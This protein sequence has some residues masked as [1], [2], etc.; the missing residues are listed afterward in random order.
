MN[1]HKFKENRSHVPI[2]EM[3]INWTNFLDGVDDA[4]FESFIG[5]VDHFTGRNMIPRPKQ[6]LQLIAIIIDP[7]RCLPTPPRSSNHQIDPLTV[8]PIALNAFAYLASLIRVA[9]SDSIL[10][11]LPGYDLDSEVIIDIENDTRIPNP[12]HTTTE[13]IS[14]TGETESPLLLIV[15]QILKERNL[16]S[17]LF[18][19]ESLSESSLKTIDNLKLDVKISSGAWDLLGLLT[20]AWELDYKLDY[21][22]DQKLDIS[23]IKPLELNNSDHY[24]MLSYSPHLLRQF[25]KGPGGSRTIDSQLLK[26]IFYP[27]SPSGAS[28]SC[29]WG[30]V[31]NNLEEARKV[32]I[33]LLGLLQDLDAAG[34]LDQ[35]SL[36]QEMSSHMMTISDSPT[37]QTFINRLPAHHPKFNANLTLA[38]FLSITRSKPISKTGLTRTDSQSSLSSRGGASSGGFSSSSSLRRNT[39]QARLTFATESSQTSKLFD[40]PSLDYLASQVFGR[41]PMEM[42]AMEKSNVKYNGISKKKFAEVE[43]RYRTVLLSLLSYVRSVFS[44]SSSSN[45]K[46]DQVDEE[47]EW[48]KS[49]KDGKVWKA[50]M[51]AHVTILT[52]EGSCLGGN[53]EDWNEDVRKE[54]NLCRKRFERCLETLNLNA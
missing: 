47:N 20:L 3:P 39:S 53:R 38:F 7:V 6:I 8:T 14:F 26:I 18:N 41:M 35:G 31:V 10:R 45:S 9:G 51:E 21:K 49:I 54:L 2:M 50:L 24:N 22:L 43:I 32:S 37:L 11:C 48:K 28:G 1:Y 42:V 29:V 12:R 52:L 30:N 5:L 17:L 25:T 15:V 4:E 46:D 13:E 44:I 23:D 33:R 16:W 19:I 40:F 27:F 34:K 36:I